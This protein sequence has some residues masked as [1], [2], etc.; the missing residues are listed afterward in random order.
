MKSNVEEKKDKEKQEKRTLKASVK[1]LENAKHVPKTT[2]KT[3]RPSL[4]LSQQRSM[5]KM[6][7]SCPS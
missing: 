2:S 3:P 1:G 6:A 4:K 7:A 5:A